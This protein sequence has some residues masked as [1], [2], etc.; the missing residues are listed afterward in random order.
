[1]DVER[2]MAQ[3]QRDKT[4]DRQ[5]TPQPGESTGP[6]PTETNFRWK[7][8]IFYLSFPVKSTLFENMNEVSMFRI[9]IILKCQRTFSASQ[10]YDQKMKDLAD[11]LK[12]LPETE[13]KSRS[14]IKVQF[15]SGALMT[16]TLILP[17]RD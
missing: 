17:G 16:S 8:G 12:E 10:E 4:P 15:K 3:A 5:S 7:L 9:E 13:E 2:Q 1:V 6:K 11:K 14:Q